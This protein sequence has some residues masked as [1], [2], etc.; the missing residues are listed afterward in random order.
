MGSW[1]MLQQVPQLGLALLQMHIPAG[2]RV[3][4]ARG[5][6]V[7]SIRRRVGSGCGMGDALTAASAPIHLLC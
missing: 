2:S 7:G 4:P 3:T 5:F 1:T 6:A